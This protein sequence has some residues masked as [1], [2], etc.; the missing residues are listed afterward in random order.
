MSATQQ[1][2]HSLTHTPS[3]HSI[4]QRFKSKE[5]KGYVPGSYILRL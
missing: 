4:K 3:L 1:R 5:E 2:V